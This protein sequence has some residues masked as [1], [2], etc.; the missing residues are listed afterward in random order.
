MAILKAINSIM[1]KLFVNDLPSVK[2][3]DLFIEYDFTYYYIIEYISKVLVTYTID[4]KFMMHDYFNNVFLKI[5]DIW[6]FCNG[7][8][9]II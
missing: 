7:V 8:Y 9:I 4:N 3:Q 5:L 6:G 1:N 2:K